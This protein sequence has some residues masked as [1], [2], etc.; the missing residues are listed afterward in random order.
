MFK[1]NLPSSKDYILSG[2]QQIIYVKHGPTLEID[3]D[4]FNEAIEKIHDPYNNFT[5]LEQGEIQIYFEK[6]ISNEISINCI[7]GIRTEVLIYIGYNCDYCKYSINDDYYYC[8]E[9][10][11]D[12]CNICYQAGEELEEESKQDDIEAEDEDG[13]YPK[14]DFC[15]KNHL[16]KIKTRRICD[17]NMCEINCDIC[18]N[19]ILEPTFYTDETIL[20]PDNSTSFDLCFEC[21]KDNPEIVVEKDLKKVNLN[22]PCLN[23]YFDNMIDWICIL[24]DRSNSLIL[25]NK[26]TMEYCLCSQNMINQYGYY[27]ISLERLNSFLNDKGYSENII[28]DILVDINVTLF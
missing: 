21:Y 5:R 19:R 14:R 4:Y 15:K 12:M 10:H 23:C 28:Y 18:E 1:I 24:K 17:Y 16:E 20:N 2:Y 27:V 3:L 6:L 9:C 8:Y 11:K 25:I 26:N 22:F 13:E 7:N